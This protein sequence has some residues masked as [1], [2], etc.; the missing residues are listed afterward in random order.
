MHPI[1]FEYGRLHLYTF[2]VFVALGFTAGMWVG[3]REAERFGL[4]KQAFQDLCFTL[5]VSSVAGARLFFVLLEWKYF[6][7][8]PLHV[9]SLW[10]GGL[11]FYGGFL[12]A[13]LAVVWH[14]RRKG[15]SPWDAADAIAPG[16]AL[17]QAFGRLGC[18]FA[19]CCYGAACNLPWAITFHDP[20]R[21]GDAP[22]GVPLHP[23][24]LYEAIGNFALF[25]LLFVFLAPKRRFR[26]QLFA[27]YL[28]LY[29]VL[30]FVV[31]LFRADP[32]GSFGPLSTSQ[33]LGIPLF[34]LGLWLLFGK[35]GTKQVLEP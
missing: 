10:E 7:A 5:L 14:V 19:G 25:T 31:E 28:T 32:R 17:G 16:L 13:A 35:K 12:G 22:L 1:L 30:R 21:A 26:G 29:P 4:D 23:T 2:G 15:L 9:F 11:V 33:A 24:Q 3:G 18:T 8:H 20:R 6:A 34:A 27:T